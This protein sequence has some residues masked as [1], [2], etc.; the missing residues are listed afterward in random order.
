MPTTPVIPNLTLHGLPQL[1][2]RELGERTLASA[3]RAS[4][5]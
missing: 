5:R 4:R 1:I 3:V 2:R